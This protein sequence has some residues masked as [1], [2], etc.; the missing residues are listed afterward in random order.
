[1]GVCV[2]S[3]MPGFFSFVFQFVHSFRMEFIVCVLLSEFMGYCLKY[4]RTPLGY[5]LMFEFTINLIVHH[6]IS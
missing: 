1:M 5:L 2:L 4:F 6:L 3:N